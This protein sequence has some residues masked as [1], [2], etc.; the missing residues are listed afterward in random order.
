MLLSLSK[1]YL[2][3]S[4]LMLRSCGGYLL[5]NKLLLRRGL[6]ILNPSLSIGYWSKAEGNDADGVDQ[7]QSSSGS[8]KSSSLIS[9]FGDNSPIVSPLIILP[10]T[11]KPI[12]PGFLSAFQVKDKTT[13]DALINKN[14]PHNY[15]GVFLRQP[16][17]SPMDEKKSEIITSVDDIHKVGTFAQIVN[18]VQTDAGI[19]LLVMGHRRISLGEINAFGPPTIANVKHWAKPPMKEASVA[20]KAYCNEILALA[21]DIIKIDPLLHAQLSLQEWTSRVDFRDPYRVADVAMA[22]VDMKGEESHELQKVLEAEDIEQRLAITFD[23]LAKE[24]EFLKLQNDLH[25][26]VEDKVSKQQKEYFLREQLKT[27]K[28]V[29]DLDYHAL[30]CH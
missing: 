30:I 7:S 3:A 10:T 20:V 16:D 29:F 9:S 24:R 15:V 12:F 21:R 27:I 19:Q 2:M 14:R 18:I 13:I 17:A 26:Q 4:L 11:R 5:K 8:G 23:L 28:K 25:K 1:L 6:H 22:L